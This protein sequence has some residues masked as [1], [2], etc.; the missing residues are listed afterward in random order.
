ML[1]LTAAAI[2]SQGVAVDGTGTVEAARCV[3]TAIGTNM[4]ASGK[5][6]L[7]YVWDVNGN[8]RENKAKPD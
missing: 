6:T 4:A 1:T 3:V 8:I 7:I 5:R 2:W